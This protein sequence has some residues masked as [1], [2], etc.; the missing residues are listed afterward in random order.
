MR[1]F[2][3]VRASATP[4]LKGPGGPA[5]V[6]PASAAEA[7][8][9]LWL[10]S[11][12]PAVGRFA[13]LHPAEAGFTGKP[14]AGLCS[15]EFLSGRKSLPDSG[16]GT[17]SNFGCFGGEP[18]GFPAGQ[19]EGYQV[20]FRLFWGRADGIPCQTAGKARGQIS[21]VLGEDLC[22]SPPDGGKG[23]AQAVF[24]DADSAATRFPTGRADVSGA[25]RAGRTGTAK[26]RPAGRPFARKEL[27]QNLI[28]SAG[29]RLQRSLCKPPAQPGA[30]IQGGAF[31]RPRPSW[32]P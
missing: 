21:V 1:L 27:R 16:K 2:K 4:R 5:R 15:A 24:L 12:F 7:G 8:I 31:M 9:S 11:A 13:A 26:G 10:S 29:N 19:R 17:K 22:D 3:K 18:M 6:V 32:I 25:P 28:S 23:P 14:L 20:E 30:M